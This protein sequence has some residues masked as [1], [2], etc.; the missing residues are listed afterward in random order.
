MLIST[1]DHVPGKTIQE[2]LG[3]VFGEV[4]NGV[5]ALKDLKAGFTNI[6]G[7]RSGSYEKELLNSREDALR[8]LSERASSLGANAILGAKVDYET[9]GN[10]GS[11][12]LVVASGTAV[13][14]E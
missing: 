2:N 13:R 8:E 11:M 7:G 14:L 12:L 4:V 1:I 10:G 5:D 9:L 3:I 6:F